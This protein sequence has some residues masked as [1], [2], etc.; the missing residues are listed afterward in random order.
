MVVYSQHALNQMRERDISK[1]EISFILNKPDGLVE[2]SSGKF[3][4]VKLV[5]KNSR[6][7]LLV[8]IYR[9]TDAGYRIITAF[10]TS[11]INKYLKQL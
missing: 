10:L 6:P 8:V 3:Q 7:F 9:Q 2:Q 1:R 5:I 4:A 11:K